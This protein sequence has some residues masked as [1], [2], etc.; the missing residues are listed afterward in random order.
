MSLLAL[1]QDGK[2]EQEVSQTSLDN[3]FFKGETFSKESGLSRFPKSIIRNFGYFRIINQE[4]IS[5]MQRISNKNMKIQKKS[6]YYKD[7]SKCPEI[8]G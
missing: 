6:P 3:L 4:S 8:Q 5:I 7:Y 2:L 1:L